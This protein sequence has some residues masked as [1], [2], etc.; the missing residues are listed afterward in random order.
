[1]LEEYYSRSLEK[2]EPEKKWYNINNGKPYQ[3]LKDCK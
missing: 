2:P 1:M 3:V